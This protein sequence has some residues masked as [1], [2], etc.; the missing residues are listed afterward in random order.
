MIKLLGPVNYNIRK[1]PRGRVLTVHVDKL[2]PYLVRR[3]EASQVNHGQAPA[4]AELDS[5][6]RRLKP[7]GHLKPPQRYCRRLTVVPVCRSGMERSF[8]CNRCGEVHRTRKALRVYL[9]QHY[10]EPGRCGRMVVLFE[11]DNLQQQQALIPE[12]EDLQRR[13]QRWSSAL[14][15]IGLLLRP[16]NQA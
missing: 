6:P 11:C 4:L 14:P 10:V 3:D 5:L 7:R 2:K 16:P 8:N 15:G 12:H 9:R 1:S 13:T